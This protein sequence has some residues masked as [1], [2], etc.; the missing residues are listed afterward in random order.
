MR[1]ISCRDSDIGKPITCPEDAVRIFLP[2]TLPDR[3]TLIVM[4]LDARRT[5]IT[6][7]R[8]AIGG[9]DYVSCEPKLV[10]RPAVE[11]DAMYI[12]IAHNHPSG[13]PTPSQADIE[14]TR[15]IEAG[16]MILGIGYIDHLVLA[17][18]GRYRSIAEY[19]WGC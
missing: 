4:C 8:V 17:S 10:F 12:L 3:E 16:A 1:R 7:C 15:L 13:N 19:N 2:L 14:T 9:V 18:S 11:C 6:A 5:L